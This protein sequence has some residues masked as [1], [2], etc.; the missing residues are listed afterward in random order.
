MP[1]GLGKPV[2]ITLDGA[3]L[4]LVTSKGR[5]VFKDIDPRSFATLART[6]SSGE[7]PSITI[8]TIPS[9]RDG[10]ARVLYSPSLIGTWE[11]AALYDSDVLFKALFSRLPFGPDYVFNQPKSALYRAFPGSP[12]GGSMRLWITSKRVVLEERGGVLVPAHHGMRILSETF[13]DGR[14]QE[15]PEMEAY[16]AKLTAEWDRLA[17]KIWPFRAVEDMARATAIVF[18]ARSESVP[19]DP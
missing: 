8:G 2:R 18:W 3:A 13:L 1:G 4:V 7:V 5:Y 17:E 12:Q 6:V 11:G 10:Y 9:E 16:A 14:S 19:I 15:D